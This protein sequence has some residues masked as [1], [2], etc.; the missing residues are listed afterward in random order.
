MTQE[1]NLPSPDDIATF[2]ENIL[3]KLTYAI[4]KDAGHASQL[5][6]YEAVALATRDRMIDRWMDRTR[7]TYRQNG[8]RVYYL[9]L[10]FLIGRLLTDSLSNL[11]LLD[12]AREALAELG[13]DFDQI[14][15][16]E[17]DA[18]LGNGGLGRLAACFMESMATLGVAAY[19]YG[20]RYDHG[21]FRQAIVDG[22]QHEQTETWLNFGNPWEF[23]RAEVSYLIGFGGH[24]TALPRAGDEQALSQHFWHWAEGVRAIAYDTPTVGWRGS[25]V[26][27]LRLWRARA[28]ADFH[29]ERFNAGDH[30]GA[31]AEGARA[32][33]ISRVLYPADST[34]AGQ[35]LRL[36]QEYFFVA[37]SLQDLLRRHLDQHQS[38]LSLPEYN[39]IQLNDTHPAIAVAELMRLLVDVHD[40]PWEK[41]WA[42]TVATLSYTNH[43]LLPEALETWPV[44]L[45][46]RLLPRHMQII[47]L[48]NAQH[49]DSLRARDINDAR[50]LRS[51]SLIEEDH[52]RRVRMGNLAF[53]G[54]H[55]V[56]GVSALHTQLMRET[57]FTD[58]HRL[59][60][61]RISNKTNGITFRRWLYQA[62]PS[63]TR[64]LVE[65]VGEELLDAPETRLREL[66]PFAEQAEFRRRFAE[67]RLANKELLAG[68]IQERVGI[69]VDP[70]ALFDVHVK[71]IH[72]Y[73]RQLLNLLHTVALYQAI[74][75]D[76]G[77][78][79]VPR[80]KIFAGKAAAS[81][82]TAK[83]IIKLTNDI[84]RTI[85]DDPTV[86]DLLKVVFL[87]NY[88]VSLA[89]RIIPAADL[90]EQIS[91]AGLEASGTSNMKFALNGALT[92][93]TLDGANVEMSEQIGLEHMFIFGMT[94]QEVEARK[95]A[96]EYN[97]E[98]TIYQ[99]PRLNEVL[100]AI[101][102]G[103]FSADD[104]GRYTALIDGITWHDTF[105]VCADFEAY[106]Q[107]QRE[108]EKRWRDPARW[109]RSAVL[110]TA[111]TGWFSSDRTIREYAEEIWKVM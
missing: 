33:S 10:E 14:R 45:M 56:N 41:A 103:A 21:L 84:A 76:P 90:S 30:I 15:L 67:Q 93:G 71:R 2:R 82:H 52:G 104:P 94:A 68:L 74:R 9:S 63:L 49:L 95:Q 66:E 92:I 44:G 75:A 31:V 50:L 105:M 107:A 38:V 69:R 99:S 13:V 53:L 8:K 1:S 24:V 83:L 43:T 18:A 77:G 37:A 55:C 72:E 97:A 34:E 7:E 58:L 32:E 61:Q 81:Y 70:H 87:P 101:R 17:P 106:W 11:G 109:W 36:R 40:V 111:R 86:R 16:Q 88:N 19:G 96:G 25:S 100:M 85:N 98:A 29:L 108:V 5:D 110:N 39:A 51:V 26:N 46:E 102:N 4:G 54:S 65:H 57:V 59:Y 35:E 78:D 73:K 80:V 62:N 79:W 42:L 27:T 22:W 20:I 60:P 89:E 47:Y 28:E 12:I 48:I 91:T 3:R 6:W 23:E 64:L